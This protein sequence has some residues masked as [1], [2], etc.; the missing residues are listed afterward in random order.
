MQK[1]LFGWLLLWTT[2]L[3]ADPS[4]GLFHDFGK[5]T[6][7]GQWTH[8]FT[9]TNETATAL[10][11]T[12]VERSCSCL[13]V[14]NYST[15]V[16]AGKTGTIAIRLYTAGARGP[17]QES[18]KLRGT[19]THPVEIPLAVTALVQSP[20]EATPDFVR[21][22]R[23]GI[24]GTNAFAFV[25]LTNHLAIDVA[26]TEVI[27]DSK[28]FTVGWETVK[29]GRRYRLRIEAVPPFNSGN[30]FGHIRVGTSLPQLPVVE[31]ETFVPAAK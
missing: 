15:N 26:L 1:L 30:T 10:Q 9:F 8:Q 2:A 24:G 11:I 29:P 22:N 14:E 5:V 18:A 19:G 6:P 4:A 21:L 17:L 27:S 16:A 7:G 31:I 28:R 12:S 25:E 20:I 23:T 13:A 3:A